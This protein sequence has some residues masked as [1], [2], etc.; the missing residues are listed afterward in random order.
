MNAGPSFFLEC[1]SLSLL[2]PPHLL[3]IFDTLCVC[4]C[5]CVNVSWNFFVYIYI[6]IYVYFHLCVSTIHVL[7]NFGL[8]LFIKFFSFIWSSV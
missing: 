3:L 1:V 6:C 5:V 4:V 8:N 7:F 2:Y